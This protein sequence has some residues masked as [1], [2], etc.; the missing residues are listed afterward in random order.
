MKPSVYQG[1]YN[2]LTR[3]VEHELFPCLRHY[4]IAFYAYNPLAGGILTKRYQD[5]PSTAAEQKSRFDPD[6]KQGK[7]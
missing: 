6:T 7:E 3:D 2:A 1:M 5:G 4:K